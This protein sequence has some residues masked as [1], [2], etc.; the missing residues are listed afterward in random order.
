[1]LAILETICNELIIKQA[2]K[3][4]YIAQEDI[5]YCPPTNLI[6]IVLEGIVIELLLIF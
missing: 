3:G 6:S 2:G 4:C 1:M 5:L